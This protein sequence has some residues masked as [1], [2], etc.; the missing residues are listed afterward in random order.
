[1]K[2]NRKIWFIGVVLIL[3]LGYGI[4]EAYNQPSIEDLPGNFEEVAFVRNEQNKGGIVRIYAVTVGDLINAKYE[5]CADMF[6][7]NEYGSVTK[8]YFFDKSAPYPTSLTIEPPYY[9]TV[10]YEAVTILKRSGSKKE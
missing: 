6:P 8:I 10:Q 1:M 5:A 3:L 9:D 7:T 2:G 4:W